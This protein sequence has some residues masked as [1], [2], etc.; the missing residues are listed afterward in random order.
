MQID[1]E[2]QEEKIKKILLMKSYLQKI[3][4]GGKT[5]QL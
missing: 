3:K 4:M 2:I 5:I 1:L